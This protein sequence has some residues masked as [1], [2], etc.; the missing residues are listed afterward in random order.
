MTDTDPQRLADELE[1]EADELEQQSRK[2][3]AETDE[4]AQEWESKRA[5]PKVPGA[6]PPAKDDEDQP[7]PTGAPT[8]KRKGDPD[9]EED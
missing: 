6:P 1:N 3:G 5:D 9:S 8:D 2:L 7:T 4:V